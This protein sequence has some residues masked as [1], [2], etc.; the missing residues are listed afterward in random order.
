MEDGFIVLPYVLPDPVLAKRLEEVGCATV[1]P[2]AAPIGTGPGPQAPRLDPDHDRAGRGARRRGRGPRSAPSAA[3]AMEL[4]A[5]AVLVNTAIARADDPVA[6]A[7]VRSGS[8]RAGRAARPGRD[9]G[10]AGDSRPVEP[11][12]G[13]HGRELRCSS[14]GARSRSRTGRRWQ[15]SLARLGL[16]GRYAL[17][18]R[19]GEPVDRARYGEVELADSDTLVVARPVAGG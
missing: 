10:G 9:H 1:M 18:E 14:T 8:R 15:R 5:D 12:P 2:L 17:V 13:S 3:E 19:N 4:G 16:D 6:M 11:R 7:H